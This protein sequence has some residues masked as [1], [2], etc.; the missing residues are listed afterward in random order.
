MTSPCLCVPSN[1]PDQTRHLI[2]TLRGHQVCLTV[3]SRSQQLDHVSVLTPQGL[4]FEKDWKLLTI[5]MGMNDICD[6]C[7][8]KV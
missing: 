7:K 2:D 1:L 8:D 3:A 4:N 5:L 6:Y